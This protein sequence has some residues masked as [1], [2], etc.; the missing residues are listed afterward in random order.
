MGSS[1]FAEL[2]DLS[3]LTSFTT[4]PLIS[5]P[6]SHS[7]HPCMR[8]D[9]YLASSLYLEES[10]KIPLRDFPHVFTSLYSLLSLCLKILQTFY[11]SIGIVG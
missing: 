5:F 3:T 9:L 7:I 4:I 6:C 8:Q 11:P 1:S 10:K 2:S